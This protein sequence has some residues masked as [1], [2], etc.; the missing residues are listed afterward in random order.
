MLAFEFILVL[1][2]LAGMF[3]LLA[4]FITKFFEYMNNSVKQD[5]TLAVEALRSISS[6]ESALGPSIAASTLKNLDEEK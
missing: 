1:S 2:I 3:N 5:Y 4:I 6:S